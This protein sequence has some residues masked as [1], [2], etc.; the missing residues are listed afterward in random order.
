MEMPI[1]SLKKKLF[2]ENPGS[3]AL[4]TWKERPI[5]NSLYLYLPDSNEVDCIFTYQATSEEEDDDGQI[6]LVISFEP[7]IGE[8]SGDK[9]MAPFFPGYAGEDPPM[10]FEENYM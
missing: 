8:F 3:Y 2:E 4:K 7:P 1:E 6:Y 5:I 9:E 10:V